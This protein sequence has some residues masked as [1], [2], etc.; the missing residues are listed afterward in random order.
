MSVHSQLHQFAV[1]SIVPNSRDIFHF[2]GPWQKYLKN[3]SF[4]RL[5]RHRP[6]FSFL[7]QASTTMTSASCSCALNAGL[8]RENRDSLSRSVLVDV[9]LSIF[10]V[11][12]NAFALPHSHLDELLTPVPTVLPVKYFARATCIS[13]N[14]PQTVEIAKRNVGEIVSVISSPPNKLLSPP[15]KK[16]VEWVSSPVAQISRVIWQMTFCE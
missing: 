3:S 13:V 6:M 16:V 12:R 11:V 14:L 1:C 4:R 8:F 15:Q 2:H 7:P 9:P 5:L 10:Y